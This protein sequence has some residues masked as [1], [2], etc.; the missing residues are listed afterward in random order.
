MHPELR[1]PIVWF[2]GKGN[3]A[4][5]LLK[6]MPEHKH[7]V[8]PWGG[9]ASLLFAKPP[10]GGVEVYNDLDDGHQEMVSRLLEYPGMVM[11]SGYD[12][13]IYK[14]LTVAGWDVQRYETACSAAGKTRHTG[15]QGAGASM[16]MQPR[17]ECVYRNPA[18]MAACNQTQNLFK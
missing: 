17:T 14:P 18:A 7:Y 5:K 12:H 2:G 9:G 11:L 15:I 10:C 16:R 13:E 6:L 3:M 4:S 8:E 1:S